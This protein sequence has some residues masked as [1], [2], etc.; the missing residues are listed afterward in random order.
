MSSG[1]AVVCD[2]TSGEFLGNI[3]AFCQSE[4]AFTCLYFPICKHSFNYSLI[5][6]VSTCMWIESTT[7][8]LH[9]F[10]Y[11]C[12]KPRVRSKFK[13]DLVRTCV[14]RY[15]VE[16]HSLCKLDFVGPQWPTWI[17]VQ[18]VTMMRVTADRW[19]LHDRITGWREI[20]PDDLL[21]C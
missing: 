14:Q 17:T 18:G 8:P 16:R 6:E 21:H 15:E 20:L 19:W 11:Y 10:L 4:H 12:Y 1:S 7:K 13:T 2:E 9:L 5:E 3:S